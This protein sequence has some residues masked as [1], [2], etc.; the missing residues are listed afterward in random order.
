MLQ[1]RGHMPQQ[2]ILHAATNKTTSATKQINKYFL[3]NVHFW[4]FL[5]VQW[6]GLHTPTA[7]GTGLIPD[8]G[9]VNKIPAWRP[10]KVH[11]L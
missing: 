6:L 7:G 5:V 2:K 11:F 4:E 1:L 3:K 10:Q 9:T 8:W